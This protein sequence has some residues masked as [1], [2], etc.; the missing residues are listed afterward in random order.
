[1]SSNSVL[2]ATP[3][4]PPLHLSVHL[5]G[6]FYQT[7]TDPTV[8]RRVRGHV[9][10]GHLSVYQMLLPTTVMVVRNG[11]LVPSGHRL[12]RAVATDKTL[13]EF[14]LAASTAHVLRRIGR[15]RVSR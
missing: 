11:G 15:N 2:R 8:T 5:S 1:L 10:K 14:T 6:E 13:C 3:Y 9:D 12:G 4:T 7:K